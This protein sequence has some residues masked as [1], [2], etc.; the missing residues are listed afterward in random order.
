MY[1]LDQTTLEM[2]TVPGRGRGLFAKKAIP[3]GTPLMKIAPHVAILDKQHLPILCS[4]CKLDKQT[5]EA[6]RRCSACKAVHY[7]SEVRG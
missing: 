1:S 3:A 7:C 4:H 2:R 6:L 5:G